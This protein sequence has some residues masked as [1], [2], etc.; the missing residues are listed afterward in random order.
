MIPAI[1]IIFLR[2]SYTFA[3]LLK[4]CPPDSN[5]VD[6]NKKCYKNCISTDGIKLGYIATNIGESCWSYYSYDGRYNYDCVATGYCCYQGT[7]D[8]QDK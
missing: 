7:V 2:V 6:V 5:E 8:C 1:L 4:T 3:Q